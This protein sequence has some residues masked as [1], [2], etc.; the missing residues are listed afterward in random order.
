[1]GRLMQAIE[2]YIIVFGKVDSGDNF[3][4]LMEA[5]KVLQALLS[6]RRI[7]AGM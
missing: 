4:F 6:R 5:E 2:S 7:M 1:M 3:Y